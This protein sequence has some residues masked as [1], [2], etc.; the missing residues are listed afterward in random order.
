[1]QNSIKVQ[2]WLSMDAGIENSNVIQQ[3]TAYLGLR[4]TCAILRQI[5]TEI[6]VN[7]VSPSEKKLFSILETFLF[8]DLFI[9]TNMFCKVSN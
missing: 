9:S 8:W 5:L 3:M 1:M 7:H 6:N 4:C 2:S